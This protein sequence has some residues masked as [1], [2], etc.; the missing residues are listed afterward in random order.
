VAVRRGI[1][2]AVV[3]VL[4]VWLLL[5]VLDNPEGAV[6]AAFG[7]AGMMIAADFAGDAKHRLVAYLTMGFAGM[8]TITAGRYAST[9]VLSAVLVTVVVGFVLAF[10]AVMRGMLAA[11]A[12][13]VL[14]VYI[15]A[16]S[17]GGTTG[18]LVRYLIGWIVAVIVCAVTALVLLP[19]DRRLD[20][21][22]AAAD[23]LLGAKGVV[24]AAWVEPDAQALPQ[25]RAAFA[26]TIE[27][28][29]RGFI[30]QPFRPA[31]TTVR[32]RGLVL[33]VDEL[34][35]A[36]SLIGIVG[37]EPWGRADLGTPE[38][39]AEVSAVLGAMAAA[40]RDP[41]TVPSAAH[42]DELRSGHRALTERWVLQQARG[43]ATS[44]D[45]AD[46]VRSGHIVRIS[47]L[48]CERL[49]ELVRQAN[50]AAQELLPA[51]PSV[52][53]RSWGTILRAHL[54]PTSPW[55]QTAARMGLGLGIA[56]AIVRA[57]EVAHGFWVLLGVMSVLRFDA[58]STRKFAWQAIVGSVVG[59]IIGG[60]LIRWTGQSE[61]LL[62]ITFPIAVF[63]MAWGP[64]VLGFV[65]GQAA[66]SAFVLLVL[67][68]VDWPP[69][70][71]LGEIR[72]E[73]IA[74][75][76][77]VAV[78][79]GLILWPGGAARALHT[80]VATAMR[81]ASAFLSLALRTL[82]VEVPAADR[83]RSAKA[84][85]LAAMRATETH[86]IATMQG[87][88]ALPDPR[89]W[90][91]LTNAATLLVD[92]GHV[93]EQYSQGHPLLDGRPE[94]GAVVTRTEQSSTRAWTAL[95]HELETTGRPTPLAGAAGEPR[96]DLEL[97]AVVIRS[98]EDAH[99]FVLTLWATDWVDH[100]DRLAHG[101]L[102]ST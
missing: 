89:Q 5:I 72:V 90:A 24:D 59:V 40:L 80:A 36:R 4:V 79:I 75:G 55:F 2:A 31:G 6:F 67:G 18:D 44:G 12:P 54:T 77:V 43:G 57:S 62:W 96:G 38:L 45:L 50:G 70:A 94:L 41:S 27:A 64:A 66:F 68:I 91:R 7:S 29:N 17:L 74:L 42:L 102:E 61:T 10:A 98:P 87:P 97:D 85:S 99:A 3:M 20:V 53:W 76:A 78:L 46:E 52:P 16:V 73:D 95:A 84:A 101:Q 71:G 26:D 35:T 48:A 23:A 11:G 51:M 65:V 33:L 37:E 15:V 32:D 56:V 83:T 34:N 30:G 100:A 28:L 22:G 13:G 25:R 81:E 63:L 39:A 19:R 14:I 58:A 60:L 82:V 49:V 1:R 92:I 9:T 47:A 93:V 86:D 88:R 8:V 69:Q 21:R